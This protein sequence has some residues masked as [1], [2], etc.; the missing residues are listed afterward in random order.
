MN[1]SHY[2]SCSIAIDPTLNEEYSFIH[3]SRLKV[4]PTARPLPT[5][6]SLRTWSQSYKNFLP[7]LLTLLANGTM[8]FYVIQKCVYRGQR[9][10]LK[11]LNEY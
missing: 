9:A 4:R 11:S 10:A 1:Q 5:K 3:D 2:H 7:L 8:R 6:F